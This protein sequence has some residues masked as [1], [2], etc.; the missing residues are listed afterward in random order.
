MAKLILGIC[1]GM[2]VISAPID[3]HRSVASMELVLLDYCCQVLLGAPYKER[4]LCLR[5]RH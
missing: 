2:N 4:K 5:A 1:H 3:T